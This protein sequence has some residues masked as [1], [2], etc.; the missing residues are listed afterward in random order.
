[1]RS[2]RRFLALTNS[3]RSLIFHAFVILFAVRLALRYVSL[4]AVQRLALGMCW[5]QGGETL[6][7]D[8]IVRAIH[9]A[10]RL[11]PRSTCLAQALAA[12]AL[13]AH[14]AHDARLTIGVMKDGANGFGAHAWVTCGQHVV[15]GGCNTDHYTTLMSLG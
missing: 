15:L 10:R 1:M 5:R 6:D 7:V 12:Q 9:S 2:L 4:Q 14:Y 8:R 11:V 3:Q 13:L